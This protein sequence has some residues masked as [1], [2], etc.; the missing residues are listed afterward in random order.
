MII[1]DEV[2]FRNKIPG[3]GVGVTASRQYADF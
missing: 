3:D 1:P 2:E